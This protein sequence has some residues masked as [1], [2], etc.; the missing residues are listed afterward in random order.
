MIV[1]PGEAGELERCLRT[2]DVKNMFDEIVI[3]RTSHDESVETIAREY[4]DKTPYHPWTSK[5]YP[6]GDFAGARNA[7]LDLTESEWV[8][9][10]D[11]D[12]VC[13]KKYRNSL[14]KIKENLLAPE[15]QHGEAFFCRYVL[16]LDDNGNETVA[17]MRERVFRN[18][19]KFRWRRPVHEHIL[20]S[21]DEVKHGTMGGFAVTHL[22]MKMQYA[23]AE[24]NL[25][26]LKHEYSEKGNQDPDIK[27]FL[28]RDYLMG[29]Q[30]M[31]GADLFEEII[32]DLDGPP[33]K[34][35]AI[36]MDL[37]YYF[38]F[39][40]QVDRPSLDAIPNDRLDLVEKWT[41]QALS[42]STEYAEPFVLLGDIY[43]R[44]GFEDNASKMYQ[45]ALRKKSVERYVQSVPFYSEIPSWRLSG[46]CVNKGEFDTA[47]WH[48]A[49][50]LR[51]NPYNSQML[52]ERSVILKGL[53][54][55]HEQRLD[56][57][58]VRAA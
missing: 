15:R 6:Y 27:Y 7:A 4:T 41:R 21:W 46:I 47:L 29:G 8:W 34:L 32:E 28:G 22:P 43:M 12:D 33:D 45:R 57:A 24:R 13:L 18:L 35:H 36:C 40:R 49:R 16:R 55:D 10:E 2:F 37:A 54:E 9:W 51:D 26:I 20:P 11:A 5:E 48:N 52:A 1:G 31:K 30:P 19:P 53:C 39:G 38:G 56:A 44:R 25:R 17:I 23:S 50:A 3:V 58:K 14:P 42:F